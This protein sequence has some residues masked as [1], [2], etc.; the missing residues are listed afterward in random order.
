MINIGWLGAILLLAAWIPET[1]TTLKSESLEAINP[2]FIV[3]SLLGSVLLASHSYFIGDLA[4]LFLNTTI[5]VIVATELV[6][7]L[8]KSRAME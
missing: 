2:K 3:F 1:V 7:Y 8:Y 5:A 6:V 4:F